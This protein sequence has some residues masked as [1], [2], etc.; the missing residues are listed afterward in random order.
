MLVR[1]QYWHASARMYADHPLAGVGPGN[2]ANFY[3]HYKP[4]E[5]LESVADP[6]NFPLGI[7]TQYGPI[8][9]VGFLAMILVPLWRIIS[10][11]PVSSSSSPKAQPEPAFG[12][13]AVSFLI[14]VS[15]ALLFIRPMLMP[16]AAAETLDEAC[17]AGR[18]AKSDSTAENNT[19]NTTRNTQY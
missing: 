14:V 18:M 7:L 5:A 3:T 9:L 6:H 19:Q 17:Y 13:L 16:T 8:G 15:A 12:I 2:F 1:W 4:A 11:N 10:P